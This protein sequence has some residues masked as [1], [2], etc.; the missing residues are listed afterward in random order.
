[1]PSQLPP[2]AQSCCSPNTLPW[3]LGFRVFSLVWGESV[4]ATNSLNLSVFVFS[5]LFLSSMPAGFPVL[6]CLPFPLPFLTTPF[7][8]AGSWGEPR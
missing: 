5:F 2:Y 6:P 1:M 4:A 7:S 3:A 8:P